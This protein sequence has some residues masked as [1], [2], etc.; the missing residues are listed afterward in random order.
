MPGMFVAIKDMIRLRL[1]TIITG[2]TVAQNA[3]S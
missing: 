2:G 1:A 3:T